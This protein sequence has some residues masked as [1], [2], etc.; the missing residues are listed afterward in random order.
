MLARPEPGQSVFLGPDRP[1]QARPGLDRHRGTGIADL[2]EGL[3]EVR[4]LFGVLFQDGAMFSSM[5]LYDNVAFPL[6]RHTKERV[7]DP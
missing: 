5:N 2:L 7:G 4:K 3:Y 6:R 1:P